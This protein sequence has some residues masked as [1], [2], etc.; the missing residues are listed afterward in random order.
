MDVSL[1]PSRLGLGPELGLDGLGGLGGLGGLDG[2][3]S[4]GGRNE[5]A[6]RAP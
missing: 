6:E 2:L 3:G 1:G 5:S 4:D